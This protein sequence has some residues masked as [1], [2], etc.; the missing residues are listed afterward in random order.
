MSQK[1]K[2][3]ELGTLRRSAQ[4]KEE[5]VVKQKDPNSRRN[6]LIMVAIAL[7]GL[8]IFYFIQRNDPAPALAITPAAYQSEFAETGAE[9]LLLDVRTPEEFAEGHIAGAVNIPLDS[10]SSRLSEVPTDEPVVVYC[11]SGNRSAQAVEILQDAGYT[12]VRDLGGLV[13]W[14]SQGYPVE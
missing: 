9:H 7:A 1:S 10:L 4:P 5:P 8:L 2:K 12:Q 6:L 14:Q 13:T 3:R 11:R